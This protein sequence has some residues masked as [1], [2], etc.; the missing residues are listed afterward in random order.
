MDA[1]FSKRSPSYQCASQC[2][3]VHRSIAS[4]SKIYTETIRQFLVDLALDIYGNVKLLL[5]LYC[6]RYRPLL[7]ALLRKIGGEPLNSLFRE[8]LD[9]LL[10]W[11]KETPPP[12]DDAEFTSLASSLVQFLIKNINNTDRE[13]LRDN[14]VF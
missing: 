7:V 10:E 11:S 1:H 13:I 5:R 8:G 6:I 4:Q 14:M 3:L 12:V 9:M 2:H